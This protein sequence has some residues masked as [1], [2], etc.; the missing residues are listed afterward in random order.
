MSKIISQQAWFITFARERA[1]MQNHYKVRIISP[2]AKERMMG[3]FHCKGLYEL[4]ANIHGTCVKFFTD[5]KGFKEMWEE[6]FEP[7]PDGI[8][9]HFRGFGPKVPRDV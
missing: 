9:P 7:M 1:A 3:H 8:R 2:A 6:N 4:K 5:N